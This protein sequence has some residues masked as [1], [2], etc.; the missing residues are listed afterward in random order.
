M[1]NRIKKL[2]KGLIL[3]VL[4]VI[5]VVIYIISISAVRNQYKKEIS[6]I[7]EDYVSTVQT[8]S[9]LPTEYRSGSRKMS[10]TEFDSYLEE[11]KTEVGKFCTDNE[12]VRKTIMSEIEANLLSLKEGQNV[13]TEYE[14]SIK[15]LSYE[16]IGNKIT[17]SLICKNRYKGSEYTAYDEEGYNISA[18]ASPEIKSITNETYD[19]IIFQKIDG[20]WKIVY[21]YFAI[22]ADDYYNPSMF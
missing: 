13:I 14:K 4:A 12:E 18:D 21:S 17:V 9:M 7:A 1:S 10:D 11:M 19:T 6:K 5:G 22:P 3:T 2:N 20:S 15:K 16:F 8:Y